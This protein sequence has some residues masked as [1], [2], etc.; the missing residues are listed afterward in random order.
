[1][2]REHLPPPP[3]GAAGLQSFDVVLA[4]G[5]ELEAV[6]GRVSGVGIEAVTTDDGVLV[7][8][9][10]ANLRPL[11]VGDV[12]LA[13]RAVTSSSR[14]TSSAACRPCRRSSDPGA[15]LAV[16]RLQ[17]RRV[18]H[19]RDA[20]EAAVGDHDVVVLLQDVGGRVADLLPVDEHPQRLVLGGDEPADAV[21]P[22]AT[23]TSKKFPSV[24]VNG[25]SASM[26]I[27]PV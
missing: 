11:R 24:A 25:L 10:F 9:P 17:R 2:E 16:G 3:A 20:V 14:S 13:L 7:A 22:R 12:L 5:A 18:R 27:T 23:P 8:D 26:C 1:M 4:D 19:Q 6:L 21:G 15:A